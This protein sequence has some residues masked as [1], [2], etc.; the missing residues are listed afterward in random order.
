MCMRVHTYVFWFKSER[1]LMKGSNHAHSLIPSYLWSSVFSFADFLWK[2]GKNLFIQQIFI[3]SLLWERYSCNCR[4]SSSEQNKP[5][6]YWGLFSV[7][8]RQ[9]K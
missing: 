3:E 1:I 7:V 9:N 5:G 8:K 2:M 4:V 6:P